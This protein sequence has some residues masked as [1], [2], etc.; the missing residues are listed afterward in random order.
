[1]KRLISICL[2]AG[3]LFAAAPMFAA[4]T[5]KPN[6]LVIMGDDIG[7]WNISARITAA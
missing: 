1:V 7:M 2:V 4:E 5:G 3:T 6:I